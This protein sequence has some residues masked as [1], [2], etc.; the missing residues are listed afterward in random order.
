MATNT[1]VW[2]L[3]ELPIHLQILDVLMGTRFW[4]SPTCSN[5]HSGPRIHDGLASFSRSEQQAAL[6]IRRFVEIAVALRAPMAGESAWVHGGCSFASWPP[7]VAKI[8][9]WLKSRTLPQPQHNPLID[10]SYCSH[11]I[12]TFRLL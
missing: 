1:I 2:E 11:S 12:C 6:A 4:S 8:W 5:T 10:S 7:A 9:I 3:N